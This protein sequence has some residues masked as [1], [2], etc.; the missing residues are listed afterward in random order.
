MAGHLEAAVAH[1][2]RF[3]VAWDRAG[4]PVAGTLGTTPYAM[5]MVH[6]LLDDESGR[7]Q[8]LDIT[9]TLVGDPTILDGCVTGWAAT[10]D[11]LVALDREQPDLAAER[12]SADIDDPDLWKSFVSAL[13]RPWYAALW[14]EAAVLAN[15]PDAET[16]LQRG[17]AA[18]SENPIATAIVQRARDLAH[19]NDDT[20]PTHARTLGTLGCVYQQRRTMSLLERRHTLPSRR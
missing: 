9:A 1:G 13:W 4:R 2:E 3:R 16:R 14:A 15:H 5:A 7:R 8:W 6:G 10:L 11:A 17:V 19:G 20:L 12:L 18:T